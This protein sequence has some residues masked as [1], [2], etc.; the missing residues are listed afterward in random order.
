MPTRFAVDAQPHSDELLGYVAVVQTSD[1]TRTMGRSLSIKAL[2]RR[3]F[4]V[5]V[6][7]RCVSV[8]AVAHRPL[9]E[10]SDTMGAPS[11]ANRRCRAKSAA[12]RYQRMAPCL[13]SM[14]TVLDHANREC[15][16]ARD[17]P[18]RFAPHRIPP[19]PSPRSAHAI[20]RRD[21]QH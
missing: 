21:R 13:N 9:T 8:N 3:L 2:H 11:A 16:N 7:R 19:P 5:V 18:M 20:E 4:H 15:A 17:E 1:V 10:L 6:C 12:R 14:M